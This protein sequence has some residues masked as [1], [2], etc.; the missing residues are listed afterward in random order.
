MI[1]RSDKNAVI[2][3]NYDAMNTN[4]AVSQPRIKGR[5]RTFRSLFI[6][7]AGAL[8][9]TAALAPRANAT[10][11]VYFNFEDGTLGERGT[12]D[13]VA[14]VTPANPGGGIQ[15]STLVMGAYDPDRF[16]TFASLAI[17]GTNRTAAD[18]DIPANTGHV[19][20]GL[21]MNSTSQNDP[22][23][24]TFNVDTTF[25]QD[26][27][28]S[29]A[30]DNNGNGFDTIT[31]SYSTTGAPNTFT[32]IGSPLSPVGTGS[33]ILITGAGAWGTTFNVTPSATGFFRLTFSG[34][35]SNGNNRET[36]IDN[37]QLGGT[38]I[39]EPATVVGGLLGVIGLCWFQRRRLVR[40]LSLRPA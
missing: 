17:A 6:A 13:G 16:G 4:N 34:G 20:F 37:I 25:L 10:L 40:F 7:V 31:L 5:S 19:G 2:R 36:V 12:F 32:Q 38:V 28:L 30:N 21:G 35:Q 15:N 18:I 26:L 3:L 9:L 1:C 14:D 33:N 8:I 27:S 29:F 24:L 23:T 22:A 39:P 11:I